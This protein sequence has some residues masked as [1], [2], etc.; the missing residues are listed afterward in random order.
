MFE[1]LVDKKIIIFQFLFFT[2]PN[3]AIPNIDMIPNSEYRPEF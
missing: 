3:F 2:A 1:L